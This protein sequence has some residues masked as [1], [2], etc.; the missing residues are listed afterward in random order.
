MPP[1]AQTVTILRRLLVVILVAEALAGCVSSRSVEELASD[2]AAVLGTWEYRTEGIRSLHRGTLYIAV[3]DGRL[4][5]R[6]QD[7]W[8]G[9]VEAQVQL[10]G[11]TMELDLDRIRISGRLQDNRFVASVRSSMGAVTTNRRSASGLFIA[12]RVHRSTASSEN[13]DVGCS[14]LLYEGSYV[15]TP[16]QQKP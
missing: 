10:H 3:Q 8:R 7:R 15:C 2:R 4:T 5:G 14:S 16:F 11:S 1:L 13:V 6:L 9:R 12:E